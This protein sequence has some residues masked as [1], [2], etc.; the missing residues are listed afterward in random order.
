MKL[1]MEIFIGNNLCTTYVH[2][3]LLAIPL[4]YDAENDTASHNE[5]SHIKP[6]IKCFVAPND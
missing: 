1:L 5:I 2:I 3:Y 4:F 6:D